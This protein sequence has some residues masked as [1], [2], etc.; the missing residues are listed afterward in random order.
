MEQRGVRENYINNIFNLDLYNS[1]FD[2][3]YEVN[4]QILDILNSG[5]SQHNKINYLNI[6]SEQLD[7]VN[8]NIKDKI[9]HLSNLSSKVVNIE[10]YKES[11]DKSGSLLNDNKKYVFRTD[12][13]IKSINIDDILIEYEKK[14]NDLYECNSNYLQ[15]CTYNGIINLNEERRIRPEIND[16]TGEILHI[17]RNILNEYN[18]DFYNL[19]GGEMS[20]P[21][22]NQFSKYNAVAFPILKLSDIK[23]AF[24]VL[25]DKPILTTFGSFIGAIIA[26]LMGGVDILLWIM[27]FSGI[28]SFMC[29]NLPVQTPKLPF[30]SEL[31]KRIQFFVF[32]FIIVASANLAIYVIMITTS[33]SN[34]FFMFI[35]GFII[36]VLVMRDTCSIFLRIEKMGF[37]IPKSIKI[38]I[39]AFKNAGSKWKDEF[40]DTF[41]Q[42]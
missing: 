18:N 19:G 12:D 42:V 10:Y 31:I 9:N 37:H 22:F 14:T 23:K 17:N 24:C 16:Y 28:L 41:K 11:E 5:Q 27:F 21:K 35:R 20:R 33:S 4:K 39:K 40:I 3:E 34:R 38:L 32:P 15:Q 29:G 36:A 25:V 8:R 30:A 13:I 1:P 26:F 2:L 6:I 7:N